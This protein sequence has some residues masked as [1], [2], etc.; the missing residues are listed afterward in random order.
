VG[1]GGEEKKGEGVCLSSSLIDSTT[2]QN[3]EERVGGVWEEGGGV[4]CSTNR[5]AVGREELG[6]RDGNFLSSVVRTLGRA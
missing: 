6:R 4:A 2:E 3:K 5:D 1:E